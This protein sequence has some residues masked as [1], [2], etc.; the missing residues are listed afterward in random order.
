MESI[1]Q[2]LGSL[3]NVFIGY[4]GNFVWGMLGF[5]LVVKIVLLPLGFYQQRSTIRQMKVRP[6]EEAIRREHAGDNTRINTE[7]G[8]LYQENKVSV[9]GGCLPMLIQFPLL[10]GLYRIIQMPL[11]YVLKMPS[12][13]VQAAATF[14]DIE[15]KTAGKIVQEA[16]LAQ[17]MVDNFDALV[18]AGIL[19]PM[20][21]VLNFRVLG[22]DLSVVPKLGLNLL[23]VL[24]IISATTTFLTSWLQSKT[25]PPT[26]QT[27]G[28]TRQMNIM[29]PLLMLWIGFTVPGALSLYWTFSNLLGLVQ[30][31]IL[32]AFWS[33]KKALAEAYAAEEE[34]ARQI[35]ERRE[36][37]RKVNMGGLKPGEQPPEPEEDDEP[38]LTE[39][40]QARRDAQMARRRKSY[41]KVLKTQHRI[42]SPYEDDEE[43]APPPAENPRRKKRR[44]E[45]EAAEAQA[46]QS[47]AEGE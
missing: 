37:K 34:R 11:T 20:Q 17:Q 35:K 9:A 25:M 31:A 46:E 15:L 19:E 26:P 40:E 6:R 39:E 24:P 29:M 43:E 22:M 32:N 13:T 23:I 18:S 10:I 36:R 42:P 5:T 12:E 28:M 41:N 8:L 3:L 2:L 4:F 27:A 47:Q 21:Q 33:P 14:L 7:I 30:S 16:G 38:E 45:Q 1:Y 44:E